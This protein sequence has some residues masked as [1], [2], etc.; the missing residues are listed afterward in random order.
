MYARVLV[1]LDGSK[2][3]EQVLPYVGLI[4][5]AFQSRVELVRVIGPTPS[6]LT[7]PAHGIYKSQIIESQRGQATDYLAK[8]AASLQ[9]RAL[10]V[11]TI[12]H[13]GDPA[14]II[15]TEA[16]REKDTLIV[17]TTHGRG[18][19]ARLVLGSVTNKVLYNTTCPLLVI[20]AKEKSPSP[21]A[22]RLKI[23]ILPLDGSALAE[24]ALP[25]ATALAQ[26]MGLQVVVV[27]A[28]LSAQ[29]LVTYAGGPWDGIPPDVLDDIIKRTESDAKSYLRR[30]DAKLRK[31][32]VSSLKE[33][34]LYGNAADAI[35]DIAQKT[36]DNLVVMTTHGRSGI[37]RFLLGSVAD[38]V[39]R[40]CGDPVLLVRARAPRT[41]RAT[42]RAR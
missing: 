42:T 27:R 19:I 1:P 33:K 8:V 35:I 10:T 28:I 25:H 41:T 24:Q 4:A 30:V 34:V 11:A 21:E 12:V 31:Q 32:G 39:V 9:K 17:V 20:R 3:A 29:E 2:L 14:D 7:D 40:S 38:R 23:A 15:I 37:G 5:K 26:A 6:G 13:E 22:V 16:A 36:D 18:G